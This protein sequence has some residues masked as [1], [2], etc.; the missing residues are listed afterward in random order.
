VAIAFP[1]VELPLFKPV[2]DVNSLPK[3]KHPLAQAGFNKST[4]I[5]R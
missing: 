4:P 3:L 5:F 2:D 1:S